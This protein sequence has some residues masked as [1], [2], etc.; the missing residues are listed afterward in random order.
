M[1]RKAKQPRGKRMNPTF[2]VFC[3]GKTE[4][5][6]V[7][8]MRRSFRVPV[9]IIARVSDSNIS[10]LYIDRCKRDR[11]TTLGDKTFLMF[12]LDVPGMLGHLKKIK[13]VTLLLSNPCIEYWFLLHYADFCREISTSECLSLLKTK[14]A[15]YSKGTF[16]AAM[17]KMLIEHI[18]DASARAD[19][20]EAYA[21][22]SST[23]HLLS[24]EIIN[25]RN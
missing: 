14:D 5:A 21:N 11:F 9:E 6:Y 7:D 23:V 12:D 17:K 16:S 1:A 22:P 13:D 18:N 3:E 4:A 8:L 2:F 24:K 20:K 15:E 10:Q 19:R 25:S